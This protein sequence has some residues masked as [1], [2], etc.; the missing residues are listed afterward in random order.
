MSEQKGWVRG[1][2]SLS[3]LLTCAHGNTKPSGQTVLMALGIFT[4]HSLLLSIL[5]QCCLLGVAPVSAVAWHFRIF[6]ELSMHGWPALL[7]KIVLLR[8]EILT[9]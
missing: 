7:C 1:E 4:C 3:R 5:R 9:G 8:S 6:L 2:P